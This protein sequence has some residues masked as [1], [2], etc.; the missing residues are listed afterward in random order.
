[1]EG[2]E[3]DLLFGITNLTIGPNVIVS[4][5][6]AMLSYKPRFDKLSFELLEGWWDSPFRWNYGR[7]Q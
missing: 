4:V 1:M 6:Y 3:I 7:V 2:R 5:W